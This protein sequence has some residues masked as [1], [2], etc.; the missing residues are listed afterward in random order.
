MIELREAISEYM[1]RRFQLSYRGADQTLR[2][3]NI[4]S[5]RPDFFFLD[6]PQ[7]D[8][9][10][11]NPETV[12]KI[13]D[14]IQGA[15]LG[16]GELSERIS[17]VMASTPI[18]PDDVSERFADPKRHPEWHT[19]TEPLVVRWG[20]DELRDQYLALLAADHAREDGGMALSQ[21]FYL[22]HRAEIE[23]GVEMMDPGDFNPENEVSAYQHALW[24]LDTMKHKRFY[25]EM[26]I[27]RAATSRS[28]TSP[29]SS[30]SRASAPV[31]SRRRSPKAPSWYARRPTSTPPT[32]SPAP[33]SPS[34]PGARGSS[35]T[36]G[37]TPA[38]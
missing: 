24:L 7:S 12:A 35:S 38:A 28:S 19:E 34:I 32:R 13:E 27:R 37:G 16:S 26:Q 8:E 20:N 29:R 30:S 6:D 23:A 18:E 10:A 3:I 21:K 2:G 15:V 4:E 22:E 11:Q 1:A 31:P 14:N 25:S 33:S 9:D 17:A 5:A 36:T